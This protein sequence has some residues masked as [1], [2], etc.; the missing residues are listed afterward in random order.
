MV[1][2]GIRHNGSVKHCADSISGT[3]SLPGIIAEGFFPRQSLAVHEPG[4][5]KV[6]SVRQ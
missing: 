1:L 3:V 2:N 5:L 6:A 4:R